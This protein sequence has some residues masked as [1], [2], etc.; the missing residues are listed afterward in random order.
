MSSKPAAIPLF[1]DAYLADTT[2]LSTEE[3]GAYLLLLMAAWRQDDCTLPLDDKKLARIT[4]LSLR[5]WLIIKP[6]IL[7]FWTVDSGRISQ[8]RLQKEATYVRKKSETNRK[9]I[10]ARWGAQR[11]EN[12][13]GD[14]YDRT[15]DGN[16]PPP[17]PP[18]TSESND[19]DA[20]LPPAESDPENPP[21]V[22]A[23]DGVKVVVD[24]AP[25]PPPSPPAP[26]DPPAFD[27]AKLIFDKAMP[28]L[29]EAGL[30]QRKAGAIIG[31]W[32][33]QHSDGRIIDAIAEW[34]DLKRPPDNPVAWMQQKLTHGRYD[35]A[36]KFNRDEPTN[37]L[38]RAAAERQAARGDP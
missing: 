6:T 28:K 30:D 10:E 11:T 25:P 1:A 23:D 27:P 33:K 8:K 15:F 37:A 7:E 16:T 13:E 3:H 21:V 36:R 26:V 18:P 19:S 17:P 12:I 31:K 24:D 22:S 20:P 4:G 34:I 2:H 5:K 29:V 9:N 14:P 38:A 32:R 35:D